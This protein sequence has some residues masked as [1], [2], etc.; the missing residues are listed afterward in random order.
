MGVGW[1]LNFLVKSLDFIPSGWKAVGGCYACS[2]HSHSF[3][4]RHLASLWKVDLWGVRMG[5]GRPV[6]TEAAVHLW[7]GVQL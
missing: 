2:Y 5:A 6:R 4:K 3:K 1:S 7:P